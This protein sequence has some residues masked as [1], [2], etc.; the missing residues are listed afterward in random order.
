MVDGVLLLVDASEGPLPQTRFVLRQGSRAAGCRPILVI[1]KMD[2]HDARP[3]EVLDEVYDLFIELDATE[4][5]IDFPVI[6]AE[7][8]GGRREP[9]PRR[10]GTVAAPAPRR[11]RRVGSRR[12]GANAGCGPAG[13]GGEPRLQRLPGAYR[14]RPHRQR[15][16]RPGRRDRGRRSWTASPSTA[17]GSTKLY[18]L[19]GPAADRGHV[20]RRRR[21]RLPGRHRRHHHRR[22]HHSTRRIRVRFRPSTS[23]SPRCRWSWGVNTSPMAGR[24]GKVRHV[25][26]PPRPAGPRAGGQRVAAGRGHRVAGAGARSSGAASCSS[27][28]SSR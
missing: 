21:H 6:Y 16:G 11:H 9:R 19:R 28:F 17:P 27:R 22:D 18:L 12:R 14:H 8:E 23:T 26:Q 25:A 2:R 13:G 10:T 5:Q 20:R 1:N 24:D 7:R 4:D 3:A 15:P